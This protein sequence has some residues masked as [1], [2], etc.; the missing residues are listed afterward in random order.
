MLLHP[1]GPASGAA[2]FR[3]SDVG[4]LGLTGHRLDALLANGVVVQPLRG[5]YLSAAAL[6]DPVARARAVGLVLPPGAAVGRRAAAWLHGVDPRA[7][8]ELTAP[9]PLECVVPAGSVVPRR[10]GLRPYE[11][12]LPP[13]DVTEV[14]GVPVTSAERTAL[15]LARYLLPHMGLAVL[16]AMAG[17]RQV[18]PA[19]LLDRLEEWRGERFVARA[20]RLV[21]HCEPTSESYGESWLR[22]RLLDAGFPRAVPQV[23][24]VDG[25]GRRLYRLD[26]A[27]PE[28]RLAIEYDGLEFHEHP[29]AR[30]AD[31]RRRDD[32]ARRFGWTV[33]GVGRGEVLGRSLALENGVGHLLGMAPQIRQRLW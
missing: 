29:A 6:D 17:A 18:E 21:E 15:D 26:L 23:W 10:R 25:D 30:A 22:L 1:P 12:T 7:P 19:A 33:V 24:V 31:Q 2:P 8:A 20:R 9:L 16:D 5:V 4:R 28:R 32:L 27:W 14:H 13:G 11:A 3:R